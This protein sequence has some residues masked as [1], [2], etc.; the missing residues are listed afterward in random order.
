M[1]NSHVELFWKTATETNNYGFEIQRTRVNDKLEARKWRS[2]GFVEGGGTSNAPKEYSFVDIIPTS[3]IYQYRLKQIDRDGKFHYSHIIEIF[4]TN[5]PQK[6]SL[7]QNYPN[8]FNPTTVIEFT[9]PRSE[10]T[11]LKIFDVMGKMIALLVDSNLKEGRYSLRFDASHL[12]S[13]MY[14]YSLRFGNNSTTRKML[15]LR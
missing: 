2:I 1:K 11:T 7:E 3:G 15:L 5:T 10:K 9:I 14:F 4:V 8:P 6:F 13:G 12:A